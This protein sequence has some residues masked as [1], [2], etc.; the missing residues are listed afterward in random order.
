M[1]VT[2]VPAQVTTVEDRVV[3]N[4][5]LSQIMLL[6]APVFGGSALFV[7]LPPI[8]HNATYKLVVIALL[9]F[10]CSLLS[11]RIKGKI[12]LLWVVV[13]LRYNLRPRYYIFN[14][15]SM[16][17]REDYRRTTIAELENEPVVSN[18]KLREALALTTEEVVK[19]QSLIDNPVANLKFE[20]NKK[21]AL[22]VR[23]TEVNQ[24][25]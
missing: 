22:Y 9:F 10:A 8:F 6:A 18:L 16:H 2:V 21:G 3:G 14:K 1:K 13:L 11:I 20:F 23:F 5:G 25:S 4:L 7:V 19:L 17:C 15:R 24:E 12:L